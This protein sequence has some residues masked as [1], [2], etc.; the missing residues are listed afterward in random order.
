MSTLKNRSRRRANAALAAGAATAAL[1][2][3]GIVRA[4]AQ[5]L[6][7]GVLLPRS[8]VQGFIGQSCQIGADVAPPVI[9]ELVG[10][11]VELM[12][13]DTETNVDVARSRAERLIQEG[14][15]VLVGPFDS[16]AAIA[17]SQVAEQ[18]GIPFVINIAAAPQITEQGY[19]YVFRNFPTAIE[20]T[21]N[22]LS[23]IGDLFRATNVAPRTAV[24]MHVND[25]FGTS[26]QK[27]I[28]AILPGLTHLPFRIVETVSYDPAARDLSVEVARAKASNADFVLLV[29]RL[30]D[31]IILRREMVRQRWNHMG[32]VSPGSPGMYEDQFFKALGK[33]SDHC[34]SNVPWY[35]P[36]SKLTEM[37]VKQMEKQFPRERLATGHG[38]NVSYTFESLLIAADAFKRAGTANPQQLTDAIRATNI[39]ERMS[40]GGPIRFDAKGQVQ[41]NLSACLQNRDGMPRVVL[42]ANVAEAKPIFPWP[43]Y[44]RS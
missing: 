6:R 8:G 12:N 40:V 33:L 41:G 9:R 21:R 29:S 38:L 32:I 4:Q 28:S 19:K 11:D 15:Q 42:P 10:V 36:K 37:V 31:A 17:I 16:G 43:D 23:L 39:T 44:K 22:G 13:A 24:F 1:A 30:N 3:F 35:D 18:R 7:V 34:I 26:M 14:A 20:L 5:K 27:G 2:P 25:T